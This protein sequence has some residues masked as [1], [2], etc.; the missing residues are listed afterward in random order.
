M[1]RLSPPGK[2]ILFSP[3]TRVNEAAQNHRFKCTDNSKLS[4]L[5]Q[6][7]RINEQKIVYIRPNTRHTMEHMK[8]NYT[9]RTSNVQ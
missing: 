7:T 1:L 9:N 2:L 3:P 8:T 6:F 4:L 5:R